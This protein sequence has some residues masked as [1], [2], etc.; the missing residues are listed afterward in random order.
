MLGYFRLT[1]L[2]HLFYHNLSKKMHSKVIETE[3]DKII[4]VVGNI[5][6]YVLITI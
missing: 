4:R 1:S 2:S 3:L 6:L 5:S